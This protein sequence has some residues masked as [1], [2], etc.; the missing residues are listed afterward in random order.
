MKTWI[1]N[2]NTNENNGNPNGFKYML[3]QNRVAAYYEARI[4]LDRIEEGDLVL[5]Y[6]NENRIIAVGAALSSYES[7]DF[8][9]IKS[10]E[11]WVDVKWLWK[12][13][14]NNNFEPTNSIQREKLG[15][16]SVRPTTINVTD[17]VDYRALFEEIA[18]KQPF[19]MNI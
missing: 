1:V 11:H 10:I 6:H 16:T 18:K 14:F 15:I 7:H 13:N 5:L 2:S 19:R 12:A 17:Q 8:D 4:K 3:R 9:D